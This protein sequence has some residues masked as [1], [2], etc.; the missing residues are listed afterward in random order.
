MPNNTF[1][2]IKK[3][4]LISALVNFLLAALK[5]LIGSIGHSQ[6]LIADGIHSLSDLLT[7]GL[8]MLTAKLGQERPDDRHPYGHRRIETLGTILIAIVIISIGIGLAVDSIEKWHS[9]HS[10]IMPSPW[11][12]VIAAVSIIA[13]EGLFRYLLHHS[14]KIRSALLESNAWHNRSDMLVSAIVLIGAALQYTGIH[15]IDLFASILIAAMIF[16]M[17]ANM[18]S[19]CVK[20][21]IDTAAD[22]DTQNTIK[23]IIEGVPG[24]VGIHHLRTRLHSGDILLDA[25][26]QVDG[27]ITVSEG[28]LIGD[29]VMKALYASVENMVDITI[30]I[31]AEDDDKINPEDTLKLPTRETIRAHLN[32]HIDELPHLNNLIGMQLHYINSICR[33]DLVFPASLSILD[34]ASLLAQYNRILTQLPETEASH[35][36]IKHP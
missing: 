14:K 32:K 23:G 12:L 31:D 13:N 7:D 24:V 3:T 10:T 18:I 17:G 16:R 15:Y 30:H 22:Q 1:Q 34:S 26:L 9:H 27:T 20:E 36:L 28:H 2:V 5:V 29:L 8:V 21:L 25:H 6:A 35:L 11:V 33:I 19:T 4:S